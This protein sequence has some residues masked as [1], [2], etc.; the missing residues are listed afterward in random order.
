MFSSRDS[1]LVCSAYLVSKESLKSKEF[2]LFFFRLAPF[3][4]EFFDPSVSSW[5]WLDSICEVFAL[6]WP[7]VVAPTFCFLT[8]SWLI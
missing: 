3:R 7:V 4:P 8:V 1:V 5:V 2:L 6:V